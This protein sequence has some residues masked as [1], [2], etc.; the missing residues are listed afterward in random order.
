MEQQ[1]QAF[2]RAVNGQIN[3]MSDGFRRIRERFE[4]VKE[5]AQTVNRF[6]ER[7]R[8]I[9][10]QVSALRQEAA[11]LLGLQY[12]LSQTV[13]ELQDEHATLAVRMEKEFERRGTLG[14]E[15]L[16]GVEERENACEPIQEAKEGQE[17]HNPPEEAYYIARQSLPLP[18]N[19]AHPAS[20]KFG[21]LLTRNIA[22]TSAAQEPLPCP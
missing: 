15:G 21:L 2:E 19:M 10:A 11:T 5:N 4:R 20:L 3:T 7:A 12:Q 18:F 16:A 14:Q 22:D 8:G 13:R 6:V 9:D 17:A 1:A